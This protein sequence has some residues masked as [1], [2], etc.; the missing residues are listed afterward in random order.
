MIARPPS[1]ACCTVA[2]VP[3]HNDVYLTTTSNAFRMW[4]ERIR[5]RGRRFSSLYGRMKAGVSLRNVNANLAAIASRLAADYPEAYAASWGYRAVAQSVQ[6]EMTARAR[7]TLWLLSVA[8]LFILAIMCANIANL[9]LARLSHRASELIMRAALGASRSRL[10]RQ[11]LTEVGVLTATGT[12][13]GVW[14]AVQGSALLRQ[15]LGS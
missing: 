10:F 3:D 11:L 5:S 14:L 12:I 7:P 9:T 6:D 8:S 13:I 2:A 1:L 4:P 15:L